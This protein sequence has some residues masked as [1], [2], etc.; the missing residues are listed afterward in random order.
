MGCETGAGRETANNLPS[1]AVQQGATVA[2]GFTEKIDSEK[3]N[4]WVKEFL[5]KWRA[6]VRSWLP[7]KR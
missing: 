7:V 5:L 3:A 2:I 6:D 4:L 1:V